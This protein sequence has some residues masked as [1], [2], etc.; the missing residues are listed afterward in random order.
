MRIMHLWNESNNPATCARCGHQATAQGA[1]V[2]CAHPFCTKPI[3]DISD[4]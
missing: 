4:H 3:F 2:N 1:I